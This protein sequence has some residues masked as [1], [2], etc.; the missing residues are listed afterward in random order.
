MRKWLVIL[1]LV[2]IFGIP[3]SARAQNPIKLASLQVQLWPEYDQPRML[4][5]YDFKLPD[6]ILLPV[7]V[8]IGIPSDA[9]LEAVASQTAD[10]KLIT[11]DYMG[12]TVNAGRQIVT[13][14]IESQATYHLEYYEPLPRTGQQRNFT[15]LWAGDYAVDDL[16]MS[17]RIP[18]DTDTMVTNPLMKSTQNVDGSDMLIKDFGPIAQNQQFVLQLNY[19][20]TSDKLTVSQQNVQPSQPLS[21]DTPGRLILTNYLPY[22]FGVL[23][24]VLILGGALFFWQTSHGRK[25]NGHKRNRS[26]GK[27]E[28]E[29][30]IYCSQC[31]ARALTG[32]R[33]CRVCGTKLR[34]ET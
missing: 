6:G 5:I 33:F 34:R 9:I 15:Y 3:F 21:S 8:S 17:I 7:S 27:N 32:D 20:K 31:G 2:G 13:I 12:P 24:L 14:Q 11:T 30:E 10:G 18:V 25:S 22:V 19:V 29:S 16:T 1:L 4:V 26:H 28:P 23:G